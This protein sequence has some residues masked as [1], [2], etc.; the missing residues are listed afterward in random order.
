MKNDFVKM[1]N[2]FKSRFGT[3]FNSEILLRY[4]PSDSDYSQNLFSSI[5]DNQS[6][7]KLSYVLIPNHVM[8]HEHLITWSLAG[9]GSGIHRL[10][11]CK[12]VTPTKRVSW[13]W[14]KTA[15]IF[16]NPFPR[17]GYGT[18]SIF[19]RS[20]TDLNSEFFP[21]PRLVASPRLKN[22]VCPTIYP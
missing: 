12:G 4:L 13:I 16:T 18:R 21:S 2:K 10:H 14:H 3:K 7:K 22:S 6:K 5:L 17:A 20:L 19:K 1:K 8:S 11:L 15:S 9:W